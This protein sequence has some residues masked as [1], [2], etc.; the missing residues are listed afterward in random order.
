VQLH[1]QVATGPVQWEEIARIDH[2]ETSTMGH[3]V[4]SEGL[5]VDIARRS[6]GAVHLKLSHAR[7]PS[8]RGTVI[9]G[10]AEYLRQHADYFIN[11][12][13]ERHHPGGAPGWQ[14]DGGHSARGFMR[15]NAIGSGM[16]QESPTDDALT[17]AELSE[18]LDAEVGGE[19]ED[20]DS[21]RYFQQRDDE[22][23]RSGEAV[24]DG[25]E[26]AGLRERVFHGSQSCDPRRGV[27]PGRRPRLGACGGVLRSVLADAHRATLSSVNSISR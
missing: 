10:C 8:N 16:S 19:P 21:T 18:D 2:N 23:D 27:S 11:V 1:Y 14:P 26:E 17:L 24:T 20:Y 4:Y 12:D 6:K 15:L 22:P 5:H 25:G 13:R 9:R 3:D 7:L